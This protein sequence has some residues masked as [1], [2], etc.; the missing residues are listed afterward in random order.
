MANNNIEERISY[1]FGYVLG[2]IFYKFAWGFIALI[3]WIIW[4]GVIKA[5]IKNKI[6]IAI[7]CIFIAITI[8]TYLI[9]D[10]YSFM[11]AVILVFAIIM[12]ICQYA[13][14][15][16]EKKK[17]NY[18]NQLFGQIKF[19]EANDTVPYYL[20]ETEIS[21]FTTIVAFNTLI[22]LNMW[23]AKKE[24]LAMHMNVK[25]IDIRQDVGNNRIIN[26]IV[27]MKPLPSYIRWNDDYVNKEN[28]T[29]NIGLGYYGVV[30]MN[31]EQY[32][33]AFIG[34]ETGS[35][36]SNIL[37]CLIYQSLI[38]G[39]DVILIDFKRGVSFSGFGNVVDIYYDY[40]SII[41][42]LRDMVIETIRR[43]DMLRIAGV[44]NI[45]DYNNYSGD[46]L[47]RKIVFI[48]EL[49]ELLRTRDKETAN[50]LNDCIETLTRL[51]RAVGI[52]LIMGI[53]RPDSTI[54]SGQIKN[55][56]SYR[57]CGRFVDKEPS[58][59]MLGNDIASTVPNIKGRFIV[60]DD[61]FQEVQSFY[62]YEN[63][64]VP[65]IEETPAYIDYKAI[66]AA[67][68]DEV[69]EEVKKEEKPE[70][71][72]FSNTFEFDFSDLKKKKDL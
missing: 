54:I 53:Q 42:V 10:N 18:F 71:P 58:R 43:L 41:Q 51:S 36:K 32:P 50:I 47:H 60:K 8:G 24:L 23:V 59:I 38:K 66:E 13:E 30:G 21:E 9:F 69:T 37:K 4:A 35:G 61:Y 7:Y 11:L 44:D 16:P 68:S 29:L 27:Q 45:N 57:V 65:L 20:H 5:S 17:R 34:G 12:G 48:D 40:K 2:Y 15:Y 31:L 6:V 56:V 46:Y 22:P 62:F 14:E 33:H 64:N 28:N 19:M 49:A 72:D 70:A 26:L 1:K 52:H 39:Y 67:K 55:N 63:R 25:I 3:G